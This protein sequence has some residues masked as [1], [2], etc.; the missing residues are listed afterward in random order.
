[1]IK[2]KM[3]KIIIE[4]NKIIECFIP[5]EIIFDFPPSSFFEVSI[6]IKNKMSNINTCR[7]CGLEKNLIDMA[8]KYGFY[9][10]SECPKPNFLI[11]DEPFLSFD[12]DNMVIVNKFLDVMKDKYKFTIIISH[13][14]NLKYNGDEY[15][16]TGEYKNKNIQI[17]DKLILNNIKDESI[18]T[19]KKTISNS[20]SSQKISNKKPTISKSKKP[21]SVDFTQCNDIVAK[22]D[23][24]LQKYL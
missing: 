8:L 5:Y 7:F 24:D 13:L 21:L 23:S 4:A 22:F 16:I 2:T 6:K 20:T 19:S 1:M 10:Y 3:N 15:F 12:M 9:L 17:G 14:Q 11:L 18:S